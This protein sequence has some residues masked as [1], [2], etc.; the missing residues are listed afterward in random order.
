MSDIDRGS[1]LKLMGEA[2][3]NS[4]AAQEATQRLLQVVEA[5][6]REIIV[7]EDNMIGPAALR[8]AHWLYGYTGAITG[9]AS[10][11]A[12]A[13]GVPPKK[14]RWTLARE[15]Q[16]PCEECGQLFTV[17][18][19]RNREGY[20]ATTETTCKACKRKRNREQEEQWRSWEEDEAIARQRS[21]QIEQEIIQVAM[22]GRSPLSIEPFCQHVLAFA[23]HWETKGACGSP[24][25]W[26]SLSGAAVW[27]VVGTPRTCLLSRQ[28]KQ[29]GYR[30]TQEYGERLRSG[31]A[32]GAWRKTLV[33]R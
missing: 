12:Q 18:E 32:V 9:L 19:A 20:T 4:A 6:L 28:L 29:G 16:V 33:F 13:L 11:I 3:G 21:L 17:R 27:S 14:L 15:R 5:Y 23:R 10:T 8:E 2:E 31:M 7:A 1:L 30:E 26:Q 25:I 22:A 24:S